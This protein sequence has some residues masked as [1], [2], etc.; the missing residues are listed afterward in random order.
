MLVKPAGVRGGCP[1]HWFL[2]W[3]KLIGLF[4]EQVTE[5]SDWSCFLT[6]I[7]NPYSF[8]FPL[9]PLIFAGFSKRADVSTKLLLEAL[10]EYKRLDTRKYS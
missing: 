9:I 5:N 6:D 4:A 7:S 1:G 2:Q 8:S 10:F 3:W